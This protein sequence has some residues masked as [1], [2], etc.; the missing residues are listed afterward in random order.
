MMS[1]WGAGARRDPGARGRLGRGTW[2]TSVLADEVLCLVD[3]LRMQLLSARGRK[4]FPG[5]VMMTSEG[6]VDTHLV[7]G[8][9]SRGESVFDW[10]SFCTSVASYVDEDAVECR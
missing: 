2:R 5:P 3:Y 4:A 6:T 1:K 8:F 7:E 10:S 9:H